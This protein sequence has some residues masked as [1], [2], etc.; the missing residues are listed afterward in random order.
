M[1]SS[2][3]PGNGPQ[4]ESNGNIIE[5]HESHATQVDDKVDTFP[6]PLEQR[7]ADHKHVEEQRLRAW[8]DGVIP[9]DIAIENDGFSIVSAEPFGNSA[10]SVT[11]KLIANDLNESRTTKTMFVKISYGET[12]RVMLLGECKSSKIIHKLM[13]DFIPKPLE[14]GKFEKADIPTYFYMSEFVDL[15]TT[16]AQDPSEFCKL[17]AEMHRKSQTLLDIKRNGTWPEYE[18][19]AHQVAEP[20]LI[21]GDLW[22]GNTGINKDTN[23]PILSDAGSYFAHNEMELGHWACEF[24][25][26]FG[27]KV[28]TDRYLESFP[29]TEPAEDF[30]DRIRL[31]S[32]KGG[33]NYS[34]GHP[35]SQ[36]RTS[37][38]NSMLYLCEKYA[39]IDGIG[40]YDESID[41]I[42]TGARIVPHAEI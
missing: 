13:A 42:H 27:N 18:R 1:E 30:E 31:Y 33:M 4:A 16:T 21:H 41:P 7:N 25:T 24:S 15:D 36:L 22:E 29:K 37:A 28:Y 6:A 23:L 19:P 32:L 38:Y 20:S 40:N 39:P 8:G 11:G 35:R 17:L 3:T 2:T 34:A 10:W 12:G 9:T 5:S 14:Y 26:I